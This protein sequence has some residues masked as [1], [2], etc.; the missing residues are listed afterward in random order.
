MARHSKPGTARID[1]DISIEAKLR[2]SRLHDALGFKTKA[3]TLEAIFYF[4]ST[5]DTIDPHTL[6]RIERKLD[7]M[8]ATLDALA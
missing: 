5:R 6:E 8:A 1:L 4:V 3:E 2:F 7:G